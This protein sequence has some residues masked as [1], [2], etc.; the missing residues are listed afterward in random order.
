MKSEPFN[1]HHFLHIEDSSIHENRWFDLLGFSITQS[2]L[3]GGRSHGLKQL[4]EF[5]TK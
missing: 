4:S 5:K 2:F 1:N 3:P